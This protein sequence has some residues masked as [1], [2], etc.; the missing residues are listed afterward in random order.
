MQFLKQVNIFDFFSVDKP[1]CGHF[2]KTFFFLITSVSSKKSTTFRT[3]NIKFGKNWLNWIP[4][5]NGF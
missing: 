2:T 1:I 3:A 4:A 5:V